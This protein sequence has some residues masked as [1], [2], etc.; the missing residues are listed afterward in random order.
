M[1]GRYALYEK[2]ASGGMASV[3]IGRLLGP[4]GFA[5]TVAIKRMHQQFAED[6]EFVAMFLDE[7]RLAARVRHPNVVPTLDVVAMHGELFLVMDFVQGESL[8]RL[9]RT[10]SSRH[11]LIP[12]EM[13]AAMMVGVLHGLHAAHE[14][15]SDHGAPLGIVHRDVS[16]HNILV[17]VDGVARVL[18]FGVAKAIGR[19]QTTR[20]GQLKGKLKYMAPEQLRGGVVSR[21]TDVYAASVVLW[22][23]LTGKPLFEGDSEAQVLGQV[24]VGT[25]VPPSAHVRGLPRALDDLTMRGLSRDP[26]DR[27]A[28]A[29]DMARALEDAVPL[30]TASRIGDWVETVARSTLDERSARIARIESD[31]SLMPAPLLPPQ[32]HA[33]VT[34]PA[35]S[36]KVTTVVGNF[37]LPPFAVIAEAIP[38]QASLSSAVEPAPPEAA[39]RGAK[40]AAAAVGVLLVAGVVALVAGRPSTPAP[41]ASAT[42]S[43]PAV[44]AVQPASSEVSTSLPV[45][46]APPAPGAA[47]P[48]E[49]ATTA[50]ASPPPRPRA[51]VSHA[52]PAIVRPPASAQTPAPSRCNP[53]WTI[54]SRGVRSFKPECL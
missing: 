13:L 19:L 15:K 36:E 9:V 16:P 3:H 50:P 28:T 7:A 42:P 39:H 11:E 33:D 17:G 5:R 40:I 14:A 32:A 20:D 46:S 6:P 37:D 23:A 24:L 1:L 53:P 8:S 34:L 26:S 45:A 31:S 43:S 29:R 51:D 52:R 27:F 18:D 54:D 38:T 49:T 10:A 30:A 47:A 41:A 35:T 4:V 2:I 48:Q 44:T 21:K 25:D 22:E 12:R